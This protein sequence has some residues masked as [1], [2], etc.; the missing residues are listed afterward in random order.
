MSVKFRA[1]WTISFLAAVLMLARPAHANTIT[2]TVYSG[3]ANGSTVPLLGSFPGAGTTLLGTIGIN[4][5]LNFSSFGNASN[6]GNPA[7]DYAIGSFITSQGDTI[8]SNSGVTLTTPLNNTLWDFHGTAF[9][10]AGNVNI[11]HDDGVRVYINGSLLDGTGVPTSPSTDTFFFGGGSF[12]YDV[13]Y[14][15]EFG[16]PGVLQTPLANTASAIPEPGT[17]M[18]LGTGLVGIA[19][20]ARRRLVG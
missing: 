20:A 2:A 18:L 10:P 3:F 9:L 13:L 6:T 19:A 8:T 7:L 17:L 15:E 1:L 12:T 11:T 4:G 14:G 5:T 16:A